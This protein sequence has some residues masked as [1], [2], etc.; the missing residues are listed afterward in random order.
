MMFL[1]SINLLKPDIPGCSK[2]T[3]LGLERVREWKE[4]LGLREDFECISKLEPHKRGLGIQDL[5]AEIAS[6]Q[7][8]NK[9]VSVKT[10]NEEID[11]MSPL[12]K[13][14]DN[15]GLNWTLREE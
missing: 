12:Q 5:F 9:K 15:A 10:S 11:V 6:K 4:R 3:D 14:E 7:G 2:I 13:R 1:E 8:W